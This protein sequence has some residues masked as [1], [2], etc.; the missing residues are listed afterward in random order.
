MDARRD[1]QTARRAGSVRRGLGCGGGHSW[2]QIKGRVRQR[3][4]PATAQHIS[5]LSLRCPPLHCCLTLLTIPS[6]CVVL[7]CD[8][9]CMHFLALPIEDPF[10]D[11]FATAAAAS[12]PSATASASVAATATH[13]T[14]TT[15]NAVSTTTTTSTSVPLPFADTGNPILA[16][17][18]FLASTV[19]P[20]VAAAAAQAAIKYYTREH[21]DD[22]NPVN[23]HARA[24]KD[25]E[26]TRMDVESDDTNATPAAA[27]DTN[28]KSSA[29]TPP[30]D[31]VSLLSH[32]CSNHTFT[33][34]LSYCTSCLQL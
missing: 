11:H 7:C 25:E 17:V 4:Q 13:T 2:K 26:D 8:R 27:T 24:D 14:P 28:N 5:Q 19:S 15:T 3:R 29:A 18:A 10:L 1:S 16:Q 32:H 6:C 12:Q 9:C 23:G 31:T 22:H 20:A 30:A 33:I 34:P 21:T